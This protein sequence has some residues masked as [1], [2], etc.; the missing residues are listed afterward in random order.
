MIRQSY[1]FGAVVASVASQFIVNYFLSQK[2][3]IEDYGRFS[4]VSAGIGI[5]VSLFMLGQATSISA[6]FFSEEKKECCNVKYE[7]LKA[8][9][10]IFTSFVIFGC[11]GLSVWSKWYAKDLSFVILLLGLI[12][13]LASTLQIFIL[14]LINC[15]D[16]YEDYFLSTIVGG[17]VLVVIVILSPSISGYLMAITASA[18]FAIIGVG[19]SLKLGLGFEL[20]TSAR[21]FGYRELILLGWVAIPGMLISSAMG[22]AD[23]FLLGYMMTLKEV[24]IY[25]MAALISIGIG[26]VIISALLK[27]NA[28]VLMQSLQN[29]DELMRN[30]ILLKT[31]W[32]L[33][34]LC[35]LATLV[36]YTLARWVVVGVLGERFVDVVPM[37]LTLFVTVM[38]EGMMQF[39]T[40]VLIQK[41]K[42]YFAVVNAAALLLVAILLN[43]IL[44]PVFLI[45][46]VV[47][48]FFVCNVIALILVYFETK[49][50]VECIRFPRW[51]AL[52]SSSIFLLAFLVPAT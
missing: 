36:Y 37:L 39:M 29:N 27:S 8:L 31:E 52:F 3:S 42:L 44:I 4:L 15:M 25:S 5:F 48:T 34:G 38:V 12:A 49:R 47:L 33:C 6:V 17:V 16:R 32:L 13:A 28:I 43:Y 9:K 30:S 50:L 7:V 18:I 40:Q 51:I 19:A 23:K 45:K 10:I 26:R 20:K 22:F 41:R 11:I 24:S 21:T 2:L 46:G 14:S 1:Y 35:A